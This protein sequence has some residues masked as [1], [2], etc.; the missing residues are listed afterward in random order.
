LFLHG[1]VHVHVHYSVAL[2][3][4]ASHHC[5]CCC[6]CCGGGGWSIEDESIEGGGEGTLFLRRYGPLLLFEPL[7]LLLFL[8]LLLWLLLCR[9]LIVP[10]RGLFLL[11]E[12]MGVTMIQREGRFQCLMMGMNICRI[13]SETRPHSSTIRFP[14]SRLSFFLPGR[15]LCHR[16]GTGLT[17]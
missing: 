2:V 3:V 10:C 9:G 4:A 14:H 16:R 6:C 5:C 1:H 7:L 17:K 8:L 12:L 11:G 15:R 13:Q